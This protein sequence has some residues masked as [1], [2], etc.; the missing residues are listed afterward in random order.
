MKKVMKDIFS[1]MMI[2]NLKNYMN[3]MMI[4][5]FFRKNED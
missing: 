3:F 1:K 4:Y 5:D 2:N